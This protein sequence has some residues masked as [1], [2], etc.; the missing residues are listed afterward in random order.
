M[1]ISANSGI[2]SARPG[3][4]RYTMFEALDFFKE[5]GFEAFDINFCATIY[6]VGPS[7]KPREYILDGE[8]KKNIYDIGN[9]AAELGIAINTS[10]LPFF[11]YAEKDT[12]PL[13]D[14]YQEM[15]FRSMEADVMLGVKWTVVH[16][17]SDPVVTANYVRELCEYA[18]PKGLG[19]AIENTI[20]PKGSIAPL[21][22]AID[23]LKSEGYLVGACYD[24]GHANVAELNQ[25]DTLI[26]LGDRL[27]MLHIHD[28]F[29][30]GDHHQ[31]PFCG[32]INWNDV[33]EG[34][35]AINYTGDFNYEVNPSKIPELA[36]KEYALYLIKLA[37]YLFTIYDN[38][39]D[40]NK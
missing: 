23:M 3:K 10:H 29:T 12:I 8:W 28:N 37:K 31:A 36:R 30:T 20:V 9:K 34:L 33:M 22:E 14:Y 6:G 17:T 18:T 27:K 4:E 39:L 19:I 21:C 2:H 1:L 11:K 7:K 26:T 15:V 35:A 16:M 38:A 24:T 32:R 40:T 25:K 13:Y 5:V